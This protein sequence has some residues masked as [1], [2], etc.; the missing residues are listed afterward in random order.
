MQPAAESTD[1]GRYGPGFLSAQRMKAGSVALEIAVVTIPGSRQQALE[2]VW[3]SADIQWIDLATRK[4]LDQNGLR[5][6]IFGSR[7]PGE[8]TRLLAWSEPISSSPEIQ[9]DRRSLQ[10]F[11]APGGFTFKQLEQLQPGTEHWIPCSPP[12]ARLAWETVALGER[13]SGQCTSATCGMTVGLIS[14]TNG[15]V[16]LWLLP[17]I[18][19]GL[20]RMRYGIDENDFLFEPRQDRLT[21]GELQFTCGLLPGQTLMISGTGVAGQLGHSFFASAPDQPAGEQRIL[22]IRPVKIQA[23]DLF[24]PVDTQ[25]R[26]STSL[27]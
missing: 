23:D 8:L 16:Q 11:D 27:D 6:G 21:L 2:S 14:A 12:L 7:L 4:L 19:H 25:R 9:R 18:W 15:S 17:E 22:L 10:S 24:S 3:R 26:L 20:R 5:S 13:K 1:P